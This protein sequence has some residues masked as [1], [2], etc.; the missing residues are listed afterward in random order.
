MND[1][2]TYM[3]AYRAEYKKRVALVKVTLDKGAF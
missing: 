3:K 1:R 2:S